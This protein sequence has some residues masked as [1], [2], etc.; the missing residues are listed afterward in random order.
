MSLCLNLWRLF[1]ACTATGAAYTATSL[2]KYARG[3]PL[4]G[5]RLFVF[6]CETEGYSVKV[7]ERGEKFTAVYFHLGCLYYLY[8]VNRKSINTKLKKKTLRGEKWCFCLCLQSVCITQN[9]SSL[10]CAPSG[11]VLLLRPRRTPEGNTALTLCLC[12]TQL[13]G[14]GAESLAGLKITPM[15]QCLETKCNSY[16]CYR[17]FGHWTK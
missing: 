14:H 13:A 3:A 7:G 15:M 11:L 17:Q 16:S 6:H 1:Y 8:V 4:W 9:M 5:T 12:P 2:R 10:A